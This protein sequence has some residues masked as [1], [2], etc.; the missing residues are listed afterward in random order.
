MPENSSV[1]LLLYHLTRATLLSILSLW[2]YGFLLFSCQSISSGQLYRRPIFFSFVFFPQDC[3]VIRVCCLTMLALGDLFF[4]KAEMSKQWTLETFFQ[5]PLQ[6][7]RLDYPKT[8]WDTLEENF[9]PQLCNY[10][11]M[12]ETIKLT[13]T[14]Y[15][16]WYSNSMCVPLRSS[17][18]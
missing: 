15:I 9:G 7:V 5:A 4:D 2:M 1:F 13:N 17:A 16:D 14:A 12:S 18:I 8:V 10:E 11:A 3:S 6:P